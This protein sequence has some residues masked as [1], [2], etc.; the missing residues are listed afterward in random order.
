[1]NVKVLED[2]EYKFLGFRFWKCRFN[3]FLW[4]F[5][6]ECSICGATRDAE[7]KRKKDE[8]E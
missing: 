7:A 6:W 8:V 5:E 1:M 2:K 3:H 4:N